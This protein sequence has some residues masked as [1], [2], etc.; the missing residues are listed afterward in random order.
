MIKKIIS[1]NRST[2]DF[3]AL[4]IVL[5]I[6]SFIFGIDDK[7]FIYFFSILFVLFNILEVGYKIL[8]ILEDNK[9]DD[10]VYPHVPYNTKDE[11]D[12]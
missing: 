4:I 6:L 5:C 12:K 7:A 11:E 9:V 10:R 2:V 1:I 8:K 3:I